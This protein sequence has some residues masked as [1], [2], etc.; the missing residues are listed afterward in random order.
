[1]FIVEVFIYFPK[2]SIQTQGQFL[3][4][5]SR[6]CLYTIQTQAQKAYALNAAGQ[7]AQRLF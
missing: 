3:Q 5:K 1:M 6:E 7:Q 4:D 2:S